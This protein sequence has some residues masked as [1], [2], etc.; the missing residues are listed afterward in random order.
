MHLAGQA[1][2]IVLRA[3]NR[4]LGICDESGTMQDTITQLMMQHP[5]FGFPYLVFDVKVRAN[6]IEMPLHV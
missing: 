6:Q 5:V 4:C 1:L 3:L 2:V